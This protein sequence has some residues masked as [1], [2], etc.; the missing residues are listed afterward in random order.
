MALIEIREIGK[1]GFGVVHE[2]KDAA[3]LT[4]ARKTYAIN[5]SF[6]PTP[7]QD[8]HLKKR[9][10]REAKL[11]SGFAHRNIVPIL[12]K[13]LE[14]DPPFFLMPLA[15]ST[16]E[17]DIKKDKTLEGKFMNALMDIISGLEELHSA[18]IYHR[19]LKPGNVL[20]FL[21]SDNPD[22]YYYSVSDFGL[23]ALKQT[24]VSMLTQV[25]MKMTSDFYTAP[26]ITQDLTA[27]SVQS[28][29]YSMGCIIHDFVGKEPRV[30]CNEIHE[31]GEFSQILLSCTRKDP[32][33]RFK[34]VSA[35]RDAL[36]TL[37]DHEIS[38]S[39]QSATELADLIKSDRAITE[40]EWQSI[41][42]YV[43][44]D[45]AFEDVSNILKLLNISRL[46][47]VCVSFP[48][49][50]A[51]IGARY[52][53][54]IRSNSFVFEECDALANRLEIFYLT[55][56]IPLKSECLMALLYMGTSH[57]RWYVERKFIGYIGHNLDI[58]LVKRLSVELRADDD[59]ACRAFRRLKNSINANMESVHPTLLATLKSI[60]NQ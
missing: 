31:S 53:E 3:G 15:E 16:L 11:Q 13:H 44:K 19:D 46:N 40:A 38:V 58:D 51:H 25:G 10:Y 8:A 7:E 4:F 21:D 24:Q 30:P 60:C 2:V 57:N 43:E 12:E 39:T 28:D 49:I 48:S 41:A 56:D 35:L 23:I 5:Q 20:R 33:R 22:Q 9:F 45:F 1:G 18:K 59:D 26:E 50:S 34:T 29:I 42:D 17:S 52:A 36:L 27:A 32:K 14:E 37:I 6:Q 55:G 47:E 54:W